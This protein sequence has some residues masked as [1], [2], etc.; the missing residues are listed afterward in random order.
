MRFNLLLSLGLL[1]AALLNAAP[2]AAQSSVSRSAP[3]GTGAGTGSGGA[4]T[5]DIRMVY[6]D[7]QAIERR[8]VG[9]CPVRAPNFR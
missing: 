3:A 2:A 5:V 6:A 7:G 1:L 4:C 8:G 9:T